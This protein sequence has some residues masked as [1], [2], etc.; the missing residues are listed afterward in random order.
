MLSNG[1]STVIGAAGR[2]QTPA[3]IWTTVF[4]RRNLFVSHAFRIFDNWKVEDAPSSDPVTSAMSYTP[5]NQIILFLVKVKG[6]P[7]VKP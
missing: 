3:A 6:R 2:R 7:I 1:F 4:K 5:I